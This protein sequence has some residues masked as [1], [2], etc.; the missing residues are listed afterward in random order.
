MSY[1]LNHHGPENLYQQATKP[2]PEEGENFRNAENEITPEHLDG[3]PIKIT[4]KKPEVPAKESPEEILESIQSL[5]A[6]LEEQLPAHER[7]DNKVPPGL[8]IE[9]PHPKSIPNPNSILPLVEE[10]FEEKFP[11]D[12]GEA[13][14]NLTKTFDM[15]RQIISEKEKF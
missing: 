8:A 6:G 5:I 9:K 13:A 12:E 2:T 11:T 10:Y 4:T 7:K 1:Q 14:K 15:L 3:Q